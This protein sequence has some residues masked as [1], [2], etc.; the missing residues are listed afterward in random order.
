MRLSLHPPPR[1]GGFTLV[2][3]MVSTALII[4][5]MYILA[6][7]FEKGLESFRMLKVSG[8]M[9][10]K[11]RTAAVVIRTDLTR[12]HFNNFAD[13]PKPNLSDQYANLKDWT[14]PDQGYFRI[15]CGTANGLFLDP[16]KQNPE[17]TDPDDTNLQR[18]RGLQWNPAQGIDPYA[19][20]SMQFTVRMPGNRRDEFLSAFLGASFSQTDADLLNKASQPDYTTGEGRY[21]NSTWG[22]VTYFVLPSTQ[23][24]AG[25][26]LYAL[27]RRVKLLYDPKD[28][29]PPPPLRPTL[30]NLSDGHFLSYWNR[31]SIS[32]SG[33]VELNTPSKVTAPLRRFGMQQ[34]NPNRPWGQVDYSGGATSMTGTPDGADLLLTDVS[35]FE[36]KADW[37][38]PDDPAFVPAYRSAK[39]TFTANALLS[40]DYPFDL[41]PPASLIGVNP[42]MRGRRVFDTWSSEEDPDLEYSFGKPINKGQSKRLLD[43]KAP[44]G[45]RWDKKNPSASNW[46]TGSFVDSTAN[47]GGGADPNYAMPLRIRVK[48]LQIKIRI[49]DVKS[50]QSRQI[51]IIQDL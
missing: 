16:N 44:N 31:P 3:M 12:P 13:D 17:G 40:P 14:P 21:L 51:T 26:Q 6:S 48:A 47:A 20:P 28:T 5:I 1:R 7:A 11:L 43:G 37:E 46:G 38:W 34:N 33:K 27:Y 42:S 29:P 50:Q 18:T 15:D 39:S 23:T 35:D 24:P 36:I 4:F 41:L 19:S 49:W 8:D 22:E 2:E 45:K 10:E 30:S 9:Q 25:T 32:G